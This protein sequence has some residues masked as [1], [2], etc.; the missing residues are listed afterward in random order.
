MDSLAGGFGKLFD[1]E[2]AVK[3]TISKTLKKVIEEQKC[4]YKDIFITITAQNESCEPNFYVFQ[5]IDGKPNP[6][7]PISL[8]EILGEDDENE[9]DE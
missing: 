3:K 2:G 4:D 6:I 7:R 8:D 1:T 5:K 9:S